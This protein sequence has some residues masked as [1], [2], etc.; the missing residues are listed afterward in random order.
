MYTILIA[1][2]EREEQEG[3]AF[4][5]DEFGYPFEKVFAANGRIALNYLSEHHV[6]IL[7]TDVR[8]PIMDGLTLA[9]E[10]R[11]R[12]PQLK[13]IIFSG[14]SEFEYARSAIRIGVTSYILKPVN[15]EEFKKTMDKAIGEIAEELQRQE[16]QRRQ[17]NYARKHLLFHMITHSASEQDVRKDDEHCCTYRRMLL[18]EFEHD[19]FDFEGAGFEQAILEQIPM[20]ADYLNLNMCQSLL[21]FQEERDTESFRETAEALHLWLADTRGG[22]RCYI[23]VSADFSP[24]ESLSGIFRGL[25]EMMEYRF[26][27]P[28]TYIFLKDQ[29]LKNLLIEEPEENQV[30]DLIKKDIGSRDF[31]G[32]TMHLDLLCS[33]Y[34]RSSAF[35]QLYVKFIFSSLYRDLAMALDGEAASEQKLNHTIDRLYRSTDIHE[36]VG[37]LKDTA[38]SL[39]KVWAVSQDGASREVDMVKAYINSHY[40]KDLDLVTLA[41]QVYLSPRYLSTLFKK[42]TG[43]GINRY[44]KTVRM[45]KAKELLEETNIKVVD[46]CESVGFRNLSY[47]CQNF[48]EFYGETPE[49]YR[50]SDYYYNR[51]KKP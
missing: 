2:D 31:V 30:L 11:T 44:I 28:D 38:S 24:E 6:D 17:E 10:A 39:D 37:L 45:E 23:A 8:M 40:E 32:L 3:V 18:L 34:E 1:D 43:C 21:L 48:R 51:S 42:V 33:K 7:F 4:L 15:V 22:Q 26:F 27:L 35:S 20:E 14:Y 12:F 19:F 5:L 46:L 9:E 47:F 41:E 25:E 49:K 13:I 36:M 29:L 16:K 50:K